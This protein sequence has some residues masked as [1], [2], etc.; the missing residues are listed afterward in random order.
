MP[1]RT[2]HATQAPAG[3][4]R[5]LTSVESSTTISTAL[6][7]ASSP[8]LAVGP[9]QPCGIVASFF[10]FRG[11]FGEPRQT[12]ARE[13]GKQSHETGDA[14]KDGIMRC[15]S[16]AAAE[17]TTAQVRVWDGLHSHLRRSDRTGR[18]R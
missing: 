2:T 14:I 10:V 7:S 1:V 12:P 18:R 3:G 4:G 15:G 5:L 17:R 8:L 13:E 9:T 16:A 11:V 6:R